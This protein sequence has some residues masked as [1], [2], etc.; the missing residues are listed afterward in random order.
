MKLLRPALN[1]SSTLMLVIAVAGLEP[2]ALAQART[3]NPRTVGS[4]RQ[5]VNMTPQELAD[6]AAIRELVDRYSILADQKQAQKQADMFSKSAVLETYRRTPEAEKGQLM[7]KLEGPANIGQA[8][9]K[10]LK[11]FETVYHFNGQSVVEL[12]GDKATGIAYCTVNLVRNANGKRTMQNIGIHYYDEYV[13]ENGKWLF[14]R[15]TTIFDWET[16]REL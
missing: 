8:F 14:A 16:T 1:I 13:R 3:A 12:N 6:K 15:R 2:A 9:E 10:F 11:N 4:S 5:D 7:S